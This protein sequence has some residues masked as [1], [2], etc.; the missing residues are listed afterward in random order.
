MTEQQRLKRNAYM[1]E[2]SRKNPEKVRIYSRNTRLKNI[3][4]YK[5]MQKA[6]YLRWKKEKPEQ[7]KA[8]QRKAQIKYN[9]KKPWRVLTEE[10]KEQRRLRSAKWRQL[11]PG[12]TTKRVQEWRN[13]HPEEARANRRKWA[14]ENPLKNK[15][16]HINNSAKRRKAIGFFTPEQWEAKKKEYHYF[17]PACG[18]K[19]PDIKLTVDHIHPLILGGSNFIE[20]IQPLCMPCNSRKNAKIIKY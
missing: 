20:N 10:R 9:A 15:I 4:K 12:L 17:C 2:W 16:C 19:E 18:K 7:L 6:K 14:K 11:H 5:A 1:K 8:M 3:E 13:K